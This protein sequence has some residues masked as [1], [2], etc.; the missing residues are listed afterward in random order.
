MTSAPGTSAS[1]ALA[2]RASGRARAGA[3]PPSRGGCSAGGVDAST[4]TAGMIGSRPTAKQGLLRSAKLLAHLRERP[5]D[6][7]MHGR[8]R[9]AGDLSDLRDREVRAVAEGH[10]LALLRRELGERAAQLVAVLDQV[11][12]AL[13]GTDRLGHAFERARLGGAAAGAV[14]QDV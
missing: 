14:A 6:A 2:I 5:V 13:G 3:V 10:C 11:E 7:P 9:L 4:V 8:M 1:S 12:A